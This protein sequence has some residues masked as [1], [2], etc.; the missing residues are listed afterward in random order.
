MARQPCICLEGR[1]ERHKELPLEWEV[2]IVIKSL[3]ELSQRNVSLFCRG[4]RRGY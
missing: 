4:T 3:L 2:V 1:E